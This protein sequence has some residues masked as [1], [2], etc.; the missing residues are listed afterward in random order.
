LVAERARHCGRVPPRC[1]RLLLPLEY[2]GSS[3]T[4][5]LSDVFFHFV[6]H[7]DPEDHAANY[8]TMHKVLD[9]GQ[10][11]ASPWDLPVSSVRIDP[12]RTLESEGLIEMSKTCF[13]EIRPEHLQVHV[14]KYGHF[15]I[16][17][18]RQ[19]IT[20]Y[21]ARPV[22]YVPTH[23]GDWQGIDGKPALRDV[24][25]VYRGFQKHV[26]EPRNFPDRLSRTFGAEPATEAEA[27]S[28]ID[29]LFKRYF[30]AYLKP[31]PADARE[32]DAAYFYAEREWRSPLSVPFQP[33]DVL[34]VVV[35]PN[36]LQRFGADYPALANRCHA[37]DRLGESLPT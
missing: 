11:R 13:A 24:E 23:D 12:S 19:V 9:S 32:S 36:Y 7:R 22:I 10:V 16:G 31:F 37:T 35:H 5:Y 28:A 1:R 27:I 14:A 18:S 15:G 33:R 21:G 30:L 26:V 8:L 3:M 2:A 4:K 34:L 6:G 25:A 20:K 29:G 17:L